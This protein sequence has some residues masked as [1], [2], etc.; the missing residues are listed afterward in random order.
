MAKRGIGGPAKSR[1]T[2]ARIDCGLASAFSPGERRVIDTD[3]GAVI[4]TNVDGKYYGVGAKCP[5]L[6]LP[7]KVY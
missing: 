6:G 1:Q 4:V 2:T 7:M 3:E 5:H